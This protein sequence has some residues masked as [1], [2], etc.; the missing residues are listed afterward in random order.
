MNNYFEPEEYFKKL[1]STN[2][3]KDNEVDNSLNNLPEIKL[4]AHY[5]EKPRRRIIGYVAKLNKK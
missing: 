1:T 3:I 2:E 5:E 4:D